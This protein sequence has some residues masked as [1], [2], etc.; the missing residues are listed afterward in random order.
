[1]SQLILG[2]MTLVADDHPRWKT[3][4]VTNTVKGIGTRAVVVVRAPMRSSQR[5][6]I[7]Y[8]LDSDAQLLYTA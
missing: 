7:L 6:K 2:V 1:V 4:A 5:S 8:S 3:I